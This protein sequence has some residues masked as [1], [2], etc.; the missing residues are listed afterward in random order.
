MAQLLSMSF[1][2]LLKLLVNQTAALK[3][4]PTVA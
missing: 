4:F 3:G 2:E 1:P